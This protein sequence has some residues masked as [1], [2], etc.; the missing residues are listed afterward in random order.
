MAKNARLERAASV[1]VPP[2]LPQKI[3]IYLGGSSEIAYVLILLRWN[4]LN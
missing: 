3:V 4:I 2:S 1:Q